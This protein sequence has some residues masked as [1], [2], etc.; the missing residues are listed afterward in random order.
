MPF[1]PPPDDPKIVDVVAPDADSLHEIVW[2]NVG[3]RGVRRG[4]G[5]TSSWRNN[6]SKYKYNPNC[7]SRK[8]D[9]RQ[10]ENLR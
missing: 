2:N 6:W 8:I 1:W 7:H 10:K 9:S 4:L 5:H 3:F